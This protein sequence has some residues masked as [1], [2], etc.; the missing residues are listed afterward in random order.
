MPRAVTTRGRAR[1]QSRV[2]WRVPPLHTLHSLLL[3]KP[4]IEI[5]VCFFE[6]YQVVCIRWYVSGGMYQ[7]VCIR[8]YVP[9]GM[10][11]VVCIRG[12]VSGGMYQVVCIRWYVSGG[13][14]LLVLYTY[15]YIYICV[16]L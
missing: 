15:I 9:G 1:R 4:S 3:M 6:M 14:A 16:L 8:W 11:Q 2:I 10:Y 13:K 7:V 5:N 12:Y